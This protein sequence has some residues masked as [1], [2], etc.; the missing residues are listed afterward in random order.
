MTIEYVKFPVQ[1]KDGKEA[2]ILEVVIGSK[3]KKSLII[4][5]IET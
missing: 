2:K 5:D 3:L 4:R 1:P